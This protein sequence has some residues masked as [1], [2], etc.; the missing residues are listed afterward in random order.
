MLVAKEVMTE[1]GD[2]GSACEQSHLSE[3]IFIGMCRWKPVFKAKHL[4]DYPQFYRC[5][6]RGLTVGQTIDIDG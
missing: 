6:I 4:I 2:V 5:T 1:G 3:F